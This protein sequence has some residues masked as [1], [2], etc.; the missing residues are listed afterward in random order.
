MRHRTEFLIKEKIN[1]LMAYLFEFNETITKAETK[2]ILRRL[3]DCGIQALVCNEKEYRLT[4]S[5]I[6]SACITVC[7]KS[8][9]HEN[10]NDQFN[11]IHIELNSPESVQ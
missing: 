2:K 7:K 5:F 11:T 6:N 10:S 3:K 4:N 8:E 1:I 9:N